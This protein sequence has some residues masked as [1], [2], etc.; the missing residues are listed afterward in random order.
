MEQ[1]SAQLEEFKVNIFLDTNILCYLVDDTYPSL[2]G[3]VKA[4]SEM[5]VV[6]LYT[7]QYVLSELVEVRK[8][9]DYY[10]E[11]MR[12]A[13]SDGR[14]INISSFITH[15]KR[16]NIPHYPYE[17]DLVE[18]VTAKVE[19]EINKIV[20]DFGISFDSEFNGA[21]MMPMKEICLATKISREDSLVLVSSLFR[22]KQKVAPNRVILLTNDDDFETWSNQYKEEIE[23]VLAK[24]GYTMPFVE[25]VR[26]VGKMFGENETR[27]DL[28][29][30]KDGEEIAKEY[31]KK[32]IKKM[33]VVNLIGTVTPANDAPK[34][35]KHTLFLKMCASRVYNNIYT[36][37]LD[38]D[39]NFLYCPQNTADF[40]HNHQS[41]GD[42]ISMD[43]NPKTLGYVCQLRAGEGEDIFEK[44]NQKGNLVLVHPDSM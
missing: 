12:K 44:L 7:S 25:N 41:I 40:Y 1:W 19:S 8:K 35:P 21:L 43:D 4:L 33:F 11:V 38:K 39:L 36:V 23:A 16:Y 20:N 34:A 26:T 37:V 14:Y 10:Q 31:V 30:N 22:G 27:W 15:N 3:F 2:T 9:E 24:K 17:G 18:P 32:C 29:D 13:N 5:P 28:R 6:S 42:E